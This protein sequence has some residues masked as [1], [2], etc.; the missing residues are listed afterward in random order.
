MEVVTLAAAAAA[1]A[2]VLVPAVGGRQISPWSPGGGHGDKTA[3][4]KVDLHLYKSEYLVCGRAGGCSQCRKMV[5]VAVEPTKN[6]L[7]EPDLFSP[8]GHSIPH[9]GERAAARNPRR[10]DDE[11]LLAVTFFP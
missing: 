7:S 9:M 2:V 6:M 4:R 5:R 8:T 1:A 3:D 11:G 10:R